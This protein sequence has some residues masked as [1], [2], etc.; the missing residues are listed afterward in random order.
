MLLAILL[1]HTE[2]NQICGPGLGSTPAIRSI[3]RI[4]EAGSEYSGYEKKLMKYETSVT[5]FGWS[6]VI[7]HVVLVQRSNRR[8]NLIILILLRS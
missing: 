3:N 1:P 7:P 8:G 4:T 2:H 6:F 5:I